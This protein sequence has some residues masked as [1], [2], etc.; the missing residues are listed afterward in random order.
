MTPADQ[1]QAIFR[2]TSIR[3]Y[4][5]SPLPDLQLARVTEWL[6]N[7]TPLDP[8]IH[9]EFHLVGPAD[10]KGVLQVK[11]PHWIAAFSDTKSGCMANIGFMLEQVVLALTA[12]GI[13]CCW[14]GWPKPTHELRSDLT[15]GFVIAVAF[16]GAQERLY[17]ESAGEFKR[18]NIEQIRS[19]K[20]FD[21][22]IEPARL[23]PFGT[24]ESWFFTG[25]P[26]ALHSFCRKPRWLTPSMVARMNELNVG[27][28]FSHCW[29]A[30]RHLG[31]RP[32]LVS[33]RYPCPM[34]STM[35]P[36]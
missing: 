25:E 31:L 18:K 1:Y 32:E 16:G 4:H 36:R 5:L 35:S 17:R 10:L 6:R 19:A 14:Q 29:V 34:G 7:A 24:S 27:I 2:R 3:Q 9:C 22:L 23:A 33:L 15:R 13:G 26:G 11:A 20:G 12:E 30:A 21:S 8:H 28:A